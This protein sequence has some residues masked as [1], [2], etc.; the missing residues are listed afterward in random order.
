M[1]LKFI[2]AAK[3]LLSIGGLILLSDGKK[4][5][6]QSLKEKLQ[7]FLIL[8]FPELIILFF[9]SAT[10]FGDYIY[11]KI[12]IKPLIEKYKFAIHES[13]KIK[14]PTQEIDLLKQEIKNILKTYAQFKDGWIVLNYKT[15]FGDKI[16]IK[17]N[18]EK[19]IFHV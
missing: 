4:W 17:I 16:Q 14:R 15:D 5:S 7:S 3:I 8:F 9:I 2:F 11:L 13:N 10:L 12:K 6:Q 18:H 1:I 19:I